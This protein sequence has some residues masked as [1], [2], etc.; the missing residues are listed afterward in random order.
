MKRAPDPPLEHRATAAPGTCAVAHSPR[1]CWT[2][3]ATRWNCCAAIPAWLNDMVP[4][5]VVTG[6]E[7]PGPI[8]PDSTKGPPSPRAQNPYASSWRM[9]SNEKGS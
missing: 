6:M 4:P 2:P 3:L 9:I 1:I 8:A 7:P 5:S